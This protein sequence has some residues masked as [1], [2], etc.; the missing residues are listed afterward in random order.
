MGHL[1]YIYILSIYL[2]IYRNDL[3]QLH[4][5]QTDVLPTRLRR[6]DDQHQRSQ[7]H[8][9]LSEGLGAKAAFPASPLR[10]KCLKKSMWN[11]VIS[12]EFG[13]LEENWE[14]E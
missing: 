6:G 4:R 12:H 5:H 14:A 1:S 13:C 11:M 10:L 8:H 9:Q 2:F 3:S 7:A